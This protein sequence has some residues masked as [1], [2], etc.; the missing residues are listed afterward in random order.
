MRCREGGIGGEPTKR[1][2]V[3]TPT[4]GSKYS[5][6]TRVN[7]KTLQ[8]LL[9]IGCLVY[10]MGLMDGRKLLARGG[11]WARSACAGRPLVAGNAGVDGA[12]PGVD[13]AGEG[14]GVGEALVA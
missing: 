10:S 13:A 4:R 3:Q 1:N 7:R 9:A 8:R 12:G 2:H 5:S 6:A 14:L 11:L